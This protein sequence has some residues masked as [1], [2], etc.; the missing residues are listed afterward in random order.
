MT[1]MMIEKSRMKTSSSKT[2][3]EP[4]IP[5][6]WKKGIPNNKSLMAIRNYIG[7]SKNSGTPKWMVYNGKSY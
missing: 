2:H 5:I 1:I 3:W 4:G 6:N 7:V